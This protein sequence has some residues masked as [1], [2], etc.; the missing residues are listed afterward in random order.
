MLVPDH[1]L[2][3]DLYA[4]LHNEIRITTIDAVLVGYNDFSRAQ[5]GNR[6]FMHFTLNPD[7]GLNSYITLPDK[8]VHLISKKDLL[9]AEMFDAGKPGTACIDEISRPEAF[10]KH[11]KTSWQN[12]MFY[13]HIV[14]DDCYDRH[15]IRSFIN[16]Q[17]RYEGIFEFKG[18]ILTADQLRGQG[19]SRWE[20]GLINLL[21]NQ[22]YIQL[23][24]AYY[25]ATGILA[26]QT[27][28]ETEVKPAIRQ[29]YSP[30]LAES[31]VKFVNL[32][33]K[34]DEIV[35]AKAWDEEIWPIPNFFAQQSVQWMMEA[36]H[37]AFL[38][39]DAML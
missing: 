4:V 28:I 9:N 21:D 35:S 27:W 25:E 15:T 12:L 32:N 7:T 5:L 14:E 39:Y 10:W 13:L 19:P 29:I 20:T 34:V 11:N 23:A 8:P 22:F 1:V 3:L 16:T 37:G 30:E 18:E 36:I 26:N 17:K 33:P 2:A 6:A 38:R 31:A 24:K